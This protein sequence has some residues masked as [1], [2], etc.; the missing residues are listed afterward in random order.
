VLP[1]TVQTLGV[2]DE[3]LTGSPDDAVALRLSGGLPSTWLEREPNVIVWLAG[4]MRK[5]WFTIAAAV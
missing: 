1:E 4:V 2:V 3:K 5:L